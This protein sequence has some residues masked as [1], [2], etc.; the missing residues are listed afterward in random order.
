MGSHRVGHDWSDLAVKL[1]IR[2]KTKQKVKQPPNPPKSP[3]MM[4]KSISVEPSDPWLEWGVTVNPREYLVLSGDTVWSH[5]CEVCRPWGPETLL[6]TLQ[7][8]QQPRPLTKSGPIQN[9]YSAEDEKLCSDRCRMTKAT[10]IEAGVLLLVE[11]KS[12]LLCSFFLRQF[13][14]WHV[15]FT[16]SCPHCSTAPC[17]NRVLMNLEHCAHSCEFNNLSWGKIR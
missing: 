10:L 4:Q 15:R 8:T 12:V 17:I 6:N 9:I 5:T 1:L 3:Y 14:G 2:P 7:C 16:L 11:W 13:K